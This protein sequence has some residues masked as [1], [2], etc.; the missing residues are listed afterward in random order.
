MSESRSK[1]KQKLLYLRKILLEQTDE[2]HKLSGPE[3]IAQLELYGISAERKTIYDDVAALTESG[4]DIEIDHKGHSNVYYVASRLF[5]D[6]ELYVLADAV[7]SSKFLTQKKSNELIKKLQQLTS[8]YKA[9]HLRRTVYVGNRAKTYNETIYYTTN[10]IH[11]AINCNRQISFKYTEYDLSK[12]RRYR[13]GGEIYTV[14]PYYLIWESDCYYLVCF[15][16]KHQKISRYRVD[17]MAEVSL[18]DQKRRELTLDEEGFAKSLRATY[19]MYGG[20]EAS[21]V[22]EMSDKL[23]NVIIDRY[24]ESVHLNPVAGGRFTVRV[25]AQISPTFWGWLFQFG[26]DARVLAPEW[27]V[28]EAKRLLADMQRSYRE[29]AE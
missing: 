3:L 17:R 11:E 6:E 15:C 18:T 21:V 22:L 8:K 19:N 2:N 28:S 13:H 29:P 1:Q 26:P 7:A 23:V 16:N 25:D 9:Q 12:N 20:T 5:Q 4:L 27:V 24:G 14:S 10:A